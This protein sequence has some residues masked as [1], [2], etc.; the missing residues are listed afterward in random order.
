MLI[1]FPPAA[2]RGTPRPARATLRLPIRTSSMDKLMF[3]GPHFQHPVHGAKYVRRAVW[4]LCRIRAP[5]RTAP[6]TVHYELIFVM[7]RFKLPMG[8]A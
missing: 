5:R 3:T 8:V 4:T 7:S 1:F 2:S 6:F